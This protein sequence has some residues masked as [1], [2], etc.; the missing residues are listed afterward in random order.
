[1]NMNMKERAARATPASDATPRTPEFGR[2]SP[3]TSRVRP[4]CRPDATSSAPEIGR[5]S[6]ASRDNQRVKRQILVKRANSYDMIDTCACVIVIFTR[7]RF[8]IYG[9]G[10]FFL[11]NLI[12]YKTL[13][14]PECPKSNLK[15]SLILTTYSLIRWNV[16]IVK[17]HIYGHKKL[18]TKNID[19]RY[20]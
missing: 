18:S 6:P 7:E 3:T 4:V 19:T 20:R 10:N 12:S 5:R 11:P 16:K 8:S 1:M 2:G 13:S 17:K 15:R 14:D 9:Y